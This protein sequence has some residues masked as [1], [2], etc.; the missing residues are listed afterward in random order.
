[1]LMPMPP[2]G[3]ALAAGLA[4]LLLLLAGGVG[5][6]WR[7]RWSRTRRWTRRGPGPVAL[8]GLLRGRRR[9]DLP[10]TL[11]ARA[12]AVRPTVSPG[13]PG[14]PDPPEPRGPYENLPAGRLYENARRGPRE[15]PVYGN[16]AAGDYCNLPAPGAPAAAQDEDIYIL[17]DAY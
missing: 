2:G 4:L 6:A 5:C 7:W 12:P 14:P 11:S 13:P 8:P 16:A 15:E 10:K 1:M 9:P 17:P 3:G